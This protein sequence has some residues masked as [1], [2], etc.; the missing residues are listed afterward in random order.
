MACEGCRRRREAMRRAAETF[1]NNIRSML[2]KPTKQEPTT[3]KNVLP[4]AGC[5][6]RVTTK[7]WVNVCRSCNAQSDPTPS[8]S[9]NPPKCEST[10]PRLQK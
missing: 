1:S 10:C 6:S 4:C 8:P 3:A 7:G 2:N 5:L 9:D